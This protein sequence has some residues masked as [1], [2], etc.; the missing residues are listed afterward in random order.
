MVNRQNHL[1]ISCIYYKSNVLC[2]FWFLL[3]DNKLDCGYDMVVF[4]A[5]D[6]IALFFNDFMCGF[7][8]LWL[9]LKEIN[10]FCINWLIIQTF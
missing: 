6:V 9:E 4:Y 1:E 7:D 10:N 8:F 3:R 5:L 2:R